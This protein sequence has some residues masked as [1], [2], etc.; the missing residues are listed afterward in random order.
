MRGK[1]KKKKKQSKTQKIIKQQSEDH[2][3]T[4]LSCSKSLLN[5]ACLSWSCNCG[6]A[7]HLCSLLEVLPAK[8][9]DCSFL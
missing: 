7:P 3:D 8:L 9:E 1:K 5:C 2:L 4:L 6:G